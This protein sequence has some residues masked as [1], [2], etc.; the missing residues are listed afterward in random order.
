MT[1]R[2]RLKKFAASKCNC[3]RKRISSE[4]NKAPPIKILKQDAN[5]LISMNHNLTQ[6]PRRKVKQKL[7]RWQQNLI[8][9]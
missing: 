1:R 6:T 9:L 3:D 5:T 8:K 4:N 2:G 7:R